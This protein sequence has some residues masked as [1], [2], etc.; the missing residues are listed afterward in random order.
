MKVGI[1]TRKALRASVTVTVERSVMHPLY[2]K[3]FPVRK[4]FLADTAGM[5]LS[6][7]DTV[8]I[9]ECRPLSKRKCF[10]VVE[11]LKRAPNV[12]ELQEEQAIEQ[13]IHRSSAPQ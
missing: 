9:Q 6:V 7:G 5:E 13:V 10:R 2:K 8:R 12:S 4:R 11:V 1:V 3:R